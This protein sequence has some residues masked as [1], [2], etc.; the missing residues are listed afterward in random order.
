MNLFQ[1]RLSPFALVFFIVA[2]VMLQQT[3]DS[4][5][6]L[7]KDAVIDVADG[8]LILRDHNLG[9]YLNNEKIG[10]SQFVLKESGNGDSGDALNDAYMEYVSRSNFRILAM[11]VPFD[12][13]VQQSGEVSDDLS[14]RAFRFNFTSSGQILTVLAAV[15]E[16]QLRLS[17]SS[18]GSTR[19]EILDLNGPIYNAEMI[20]LLTARDGL[21]PGMK[22]AY[23]VYDP[24]SMSK[25][26]M[27]T[28]VL[29]QE[30]VVLNADEEIET[31]KVEVDFKGFKTTSWITEDGQVIKEHS[32]VAGIPMTAFRET[33]QQAMD[34]S[35][36]S[37][38]LSIQPQENTETSDL[39]ESASITPAVY[40][41]RPEAVR[42]MRAEI[43]G[44]TVTDIV[45]PD[46]RFQKLVS[47]DGETLIVETRT[48]DYDAAL[49]GVDESAPP[50]ELNP[51]M[52]MY[53]RDESLIQSSDE[54]I[55]SKALEIT[56]GTTNPWEASKALAMWLY[57]NIRK[58]FRVTIP[59]A[60]EVLSSMK[61]DCNEHSTLFAAMARSI[62][63][64]TKIA[65]GLVY[66]DG[67]FAYH[68]W[69]EVY[70]NGQWLPLDATLNRIEMDAAHV[71][72]AEGSLDSQAELSRLI[73]N[74]T[75][76]ILEYE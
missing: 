29:E 9:F 74:L 44:A 6:F 16:G 54:R 31:W 49:V 46:D 34:M 5:T 68:A 59:S 25:D 22:H 38:A 42:F 23:T 17:V 57:R 10:F 36:V 47:D 60:L 76:E 26:V 66:L 39:I 56:R 35:Y 63:I 70:V 67:S 65:A 48:L 50:F 53:L 51:D 15:Y 73:G 8:S 58:E 20:P 52:Q 55:Q 30:I 4:E 33:R 41:V 7:H 28:H 75:I 2:L 69:N 64:P 18:E 61:G 72:L 27:R 37:P 11:G 40:L 13:D 1:Y 45:F 14:M 71:K 12:I 32:R 19:E 24:L 21:E 3:V 43:R 62:G